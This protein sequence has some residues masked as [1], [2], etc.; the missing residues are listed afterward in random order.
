[1]T[2]SGD[3]SESFQLNLN[4]IMLVSLV[5]GTGLFIVNTVILG[6]YGLVIWCGMV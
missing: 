4:N 3:S 1:M 2:S 6:Q 5:A